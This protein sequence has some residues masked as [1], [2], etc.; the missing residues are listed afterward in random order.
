MKAVILFLL[1]LFFVM[2]AK[3]GRLRFYSDGFG[4]G[5]EIVSSA[6]PG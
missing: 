1:A 6:P 3:E 4:V 5:V 2:L